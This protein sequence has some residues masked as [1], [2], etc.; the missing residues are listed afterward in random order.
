[1][2]LP[3]DFREPQAVV[4]R[5]SADRVATPEPGDPYVARISVAA[6]VSKEQLL[7]DIL[8]AI[9]PPNLSALSLPAVRCHNLDAFYDRV[10]DVRPPKPGLLLEVIGAKALWQTDP[11]LAGAVSEVWQE[12]AAMHREQ[13]LTWVLIWIL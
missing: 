11:A 12:A 7:T 6:G 1:M 3:E 4:V 8:C 13:G 9:E 10:T 5:F 2:I